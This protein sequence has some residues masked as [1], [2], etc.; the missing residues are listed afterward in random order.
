MSHPELTP[1]EFEVLRHLA[2]GRSNK[3][4]GR[5][6]YIT[7]HTVKAHVKSILVKLDAL[8]RTET[9]AIA[10]KRGLLSRG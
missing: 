5:K 7:E 3:E 2:A 10:A 4:I 9:I 8:G 6:L 1:R